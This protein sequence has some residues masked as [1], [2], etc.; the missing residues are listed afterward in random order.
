MTESPWVL[1]L[2]AEAE[3]L[4]PRIRAYVAT[5]P[6]GF[7]GYGRG[8]FRVVGTPRVW[9]WPILALLGTE[10]VL[11]PGW[12][13]DVPFRVRN[14]P[15]ESRIDARRRFD[16]ARGPWTMVDSVT[17]GADGLVDRLGRHGFVAAT[18]EA[19]ALDGALVLTSTSVSI[20]GIRLPTAVAPRLR[21]VERWVD[22]DACQ[23]VSVTLDVPGWG[24]LYEYEGDFV[25]RVDRPWTGS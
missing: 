2:G 5:I 18:L 23:R 4:H 10:A 14:Q 19:A 20:F 22:D 9:L 8:S 16:F 11:A 13:R 24:R 1:A 6:P 3:D 25:Y 21:V 17:F 7:V 15:G 12:H